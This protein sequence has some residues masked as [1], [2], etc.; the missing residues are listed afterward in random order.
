MSSIIQSLQI[1]PLLFVASHMPGAPDTAVT[2][3]YAQLDHQLN[4]VQP[5]LNNGIKTGVSQE[6]ST[7]REK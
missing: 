2:S 5:A 4:G 3:G 6:T 1:N 7:G